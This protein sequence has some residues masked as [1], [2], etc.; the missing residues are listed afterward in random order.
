MS[1]LDAKATSPFNENFSEEPDFDR[2]KDPDAPTPD[3]SDDDELS[4][5]DEEMFNK[6]ASGRFPTE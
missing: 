5:M 1:S 6:T 4:P 2:L 3:D